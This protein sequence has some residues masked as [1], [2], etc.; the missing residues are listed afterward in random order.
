[1]LAALARGARR[2]GFDLVSFSV[3]RRFQSIL[4]IWKSSIPGG[5]MD[6]ANV[7]SIVITSSWSRR[8]KLVVGIATVIVGISII[9]AARG[10][11][12]PFIWA[13]VIA[14]LFSPLVSFAK[15]RIGIPRPVLVLILYAVGINAIFWTIWFVSPPLA[16]ELD[17]LVQS[18]PNVANWVEEQITGTDTVD[19]FGQAISLDDAIRAL[20]DPISALAQEVSGRLVEL[21]FGIIETFVKVLLTLVAAF[22]LLLA[23]PRLFRRIIG[24]F[25]EQHRTEVQSVVGRLDDV[26]SAFIRGELL[27]VLIMSTAT[28][29]G[30]TI[31][32][33]P[34]A[35]VL[36]IITGFLE[37]IPFFGPI[38]AAIPPIAL[39]LFGTN[40]FGWPG[41]VA[42]LVVAAMYTVL[43]H[44]ED[45]VIIPNVVGRIINIHPF[46][47]LFALFAGATIWG[48][49]GMILS[50]PAAAMGRIVLSYIYRKLIA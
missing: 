22:Y 24:L 2:V 34:F 21:A 3:R 44:F 29:I 36:G 20:V 10:A 27:L 41:W 7:R 26:L 31:L 32:G 45:Y 4:L 11:L 8:T 40:A 39:A 48:I 38:V 18:V 43:R 1:M 17:K 50:L 19:V 30:L 37:L 14:Y 16:G 12:A 15:R 35:L 6:D 46:V 25:P 28:Y 42:A 33:I 23:G 49:G 13:A 47:A 5:H 9:Y